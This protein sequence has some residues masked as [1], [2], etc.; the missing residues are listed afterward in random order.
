MKLIHDLADS[1]P[2]L[3]NRSFSRLAQQG[4]QFGK[5]LLNRIQVRVL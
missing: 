3:V 4:F 2:E 1:L 5:D